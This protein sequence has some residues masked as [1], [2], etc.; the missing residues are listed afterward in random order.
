MLAE[1]GLLGAQVDP[2]VVAFEES[3][4]LAFAAGNASIVFLS[5][6]ELALITMEGSRWDEAADLSR[7]PWRSWRSIGCATTRSV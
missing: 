4:A 5:E 1:A 7:W 3:S 2:A 6:A